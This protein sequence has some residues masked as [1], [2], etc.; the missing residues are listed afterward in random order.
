MV[1]SELTRQANEAISQRPEDNLILIDCNGTIYGGEFGKRND[2]LIDYI[3]IRRQ[4]GFNVQ[5][6]S[7]APHGAEGTLKIIEMVLT[8]LGRD[9]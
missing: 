7:D 2:D 1:M 5:I 4:Q 8:K 6:F 3:Q 9:F